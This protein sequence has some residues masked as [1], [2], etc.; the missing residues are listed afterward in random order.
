ML[1]YV[2]LGR[3]HFMQVAR[4][5]FKFERW[6]D[7]RPSY[8]TVPY[9]LYTTTLTLKVYLARAVNLHRIRI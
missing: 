6:Y 2:A 7:L 5:K 1:F 8:R 3:L 4:L 9:V